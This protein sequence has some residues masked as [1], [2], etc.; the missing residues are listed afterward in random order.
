METSKYAALVRSCRLPHQILYYSDESHM[1]DSLIE[2]RE[3]LN[4]IFWIH[5]FP[6]QEVQLGPG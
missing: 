6:M 4:L 5:Q 1:T 2:I 3:S